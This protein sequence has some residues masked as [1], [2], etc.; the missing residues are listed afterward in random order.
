[1][2]VGIIGAG[3]MGAGIAQAF[4]VTEG[5]E[6]R[7]T[8]ITQE[9]ADGG[10]AKIEK[11]LAFLVKKEKMTKEQADAVLAKVKTGLKDICRSS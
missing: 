1:M 7:L 4:A 11:N 8:D 5:Y 6:V 3:T 10:K 9:F 2:K